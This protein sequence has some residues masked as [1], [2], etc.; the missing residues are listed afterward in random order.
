M[1]SDNRC[2]REHPLTIGDTAYRAPV[3]RQISMGSAQTRMRLLVG[4]C[5]ILLALAPFLHVHIGAFHLAGFHLAGASPLAP[6][7]PATPTAAQEALPPESA[8]FGV[9]P[10]LARPQ[11][12]HRLPVQTT[13]DPPPEPLARGN[14]QRAGSVALRSEASGSWDKA[15]AKLHQRVESQQELAKPAAFSLAQHQAAPEAWRP[16]TAPALHPS[17]C[18]WS[19]GCTATRWSRSAHFLP[20][21]LAPPPHPGI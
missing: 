6:S 18:F 20:Y 14:T 17:A 10:A 3:G 21:A 2:M 5:V 13:S 8:A 12:R 7:L 11:V 15:S 16:G 1:V 4:L 19:L 9:G